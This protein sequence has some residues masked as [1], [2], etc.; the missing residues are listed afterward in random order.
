MVT[1][2]TSPQKGDQIRFL[3]V[4]DALTYNKQI[5]ITTGSG[6]SNP[7]QGDAGGEL[8][9]Q[10]P[11]AGFGLLYINSVIGWRIIEL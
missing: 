2:P 7:I 4:T 9:I 5:K 3:D 1:L 8:I 11:G 10:T 6:S